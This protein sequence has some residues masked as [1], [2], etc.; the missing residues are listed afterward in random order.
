MALK[1]THIWYVQYCHFI[2]MLL[3]ELEVRKYRILSILKQ[4]KLKEIFFIICYLP[5]R[6]TYNPN[7]LLPLRATYNPNARLPPRATYNPNVPFTSQ[8]D[9]IPNALLPLRATY[10]PNVRPRATYK[11]NTFLPPR[12]NYNPNVP[13]TSP[14]DLQT[15]FTVYL[16]A[17][18]TTRMNFY[19]SARLT[20]Q[21][22]VP[23]R[24][25]NQIH[26]YLPAGVTTQMYRLPPCATYK[27]NLPFT[28]P[29]WI[30]TLVVTTPDHHVLSMYAWTSLPPH[31]KMAV[32]GWNRSSGK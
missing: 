13:F 27:P 23:A 10:N 7:A 24:L 32:L 6:A 21:I 22:Y 31:L 18:L 12:G 1:R 8:R 2:C 19:L 30:L 16:P 17:R 5:P 15:K 26:F 29:R 28:S 9:L 3:L 11:P 4:S 14:R 20:I 25:T